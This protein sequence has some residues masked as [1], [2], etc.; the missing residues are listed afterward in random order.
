MTG[1][2]QASETSA[3]QTR[4]QKTFDSQDLGGPLPVHIPDDVM[5]SVSGIRGRVSESLTPELVGRLAASFGFFVASGK[6][7]V[8]VGR[9]SRTSGPILTRAV[10]SGLQ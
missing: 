4:C 1:N 9:D 3:C 5:V 2:A 8:V 7:T 10:V 6:G